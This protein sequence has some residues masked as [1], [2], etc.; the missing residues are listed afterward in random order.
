MDWVYLLNDLFGN[1]FWG[2]ENADFS[3]KFGFGFLKKAALGEDAG[4]LLLTVSY[5]F[6]W[7]R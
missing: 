1:L 4:R 5:A 6:W 2:D 3:G 7:E